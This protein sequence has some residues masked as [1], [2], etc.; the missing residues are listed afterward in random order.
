MIISLDG[1][2]GVL[3]LVDPSP[4]GFRELASAKIFDGE[5]MWSPM[6]LSEGRLLLRSQEEMKCIDLKNP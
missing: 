2:S 5:R 4:E 1:K 3:Y 6:A